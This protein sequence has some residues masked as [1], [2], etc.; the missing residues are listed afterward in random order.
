MIWKMYLGFDQ[1]NLESFDWHLYLVN[2]VGRVSMDCILLE[3]ELQ[4]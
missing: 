1:L 2:R 3:V 4:F